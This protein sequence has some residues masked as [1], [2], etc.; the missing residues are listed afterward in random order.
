ML[1]FSCGFTGQEVHENPEAIT[2]AL[3]CYSS[4]GDGA[5]VWVIPDGYMA[6]LTP[7]GT[8]MGSAWR[9]IFFA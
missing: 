2:G 9:R 4:D 1:R 7:V 6:A 5:Y 3:K 8:G